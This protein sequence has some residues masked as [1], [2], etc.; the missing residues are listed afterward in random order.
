M[1]GALL[2]SSGKEYQERPIAFTVIGEK[3]EGNDF[4]FQ[5]FVE[6][7]RLFNTRMR[8]AKNKL[9]RRKIFFC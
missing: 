5:E 1:S 8:K 3:L 7:F 6:L 4:I 2:S 9:L